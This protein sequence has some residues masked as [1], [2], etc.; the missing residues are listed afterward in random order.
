MDSECYNK[1][2]TRDKYKTNEVLMKSK[3]IFKRS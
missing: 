3:Y 2:D 1:K